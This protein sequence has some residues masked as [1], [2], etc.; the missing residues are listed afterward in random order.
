MSGNFTFPTKAENRFIVADQV[1]VTWDVVAPVI[2]LYESCGK[3]NHVLQDQISNN[4][5]YVWTATRKGYV[6]SGC[7][8]TLQPFTAEH[9]SYGNNI[10]SVLFGVAKRYTDDPPP[11]S[12]NFANVSSSPTEEIST[13]SPTAGSPQPTTTPTSQSSHG[14][15][16]AGKIGTGVGV[17]LGVLL[18]AFAVGTFIIYRRKTRQ[19]ETQEVTAINQPGDGLAPL[20]NF[21]YKDPHQTRL[22]QAETIGASSHLSG[23]NQRTERTERPP[24]ELM[25]TGRAELG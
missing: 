14:L 7:K 13:S 6:E 19:R 25:S 11:A 2:S 10:T 3:N 24:S 17:S 21:V 5:S 20:P 12:Y 23:D 22:S 8:F 18:V 1:N 15:S 16:K 4:H 9:E